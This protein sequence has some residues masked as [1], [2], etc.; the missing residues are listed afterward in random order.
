MDIVMCAELGLFHYGKTQIWDFGVRDS[1]E[2]KR[3]LS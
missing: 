1:Y 2:V 3:I